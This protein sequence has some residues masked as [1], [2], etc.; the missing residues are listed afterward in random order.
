MDDVLLVIVQV[1]VLV[2]VVSSMLAMGLSLTVPEIIA[3]LKNVRLVVLVLVANF[4]VAPLVVILIQALMDLDDDIYTGLVILAAAAGAPFLP[5]LAQAAKGNVAASVGIMVMLMV[6]TV[7]YMP[8]VLPLIL[9]GTSV[10]P[11]A[12]AQSLIFLMLLQARRYF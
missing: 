10:D 1:S 4:V 5:K 2:F 12:I 6:V 11:W 3:P 8:V 9:S 7:V